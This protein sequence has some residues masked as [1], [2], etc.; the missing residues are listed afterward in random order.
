MF[1]NDSLYDQNKDKFTRIWWSYLGHH[2]REPYMA[3]L[4]ET[5]TKIAKTDS[6]YPSKADLFKQFQYCD[7][8]D[9]KI[10]FIHKF[11]IISY[12]QSIFWQ[13]VSRLIESECVNNLQ[14]N[15]NDNMDYLLSE[16]VFSLPVYRTWSINTDHSQLEWLV[17]FKNVVQFLDKSLNKICFV[18]RSE[19]EELMTGVDFDYHKKILLEE[20]CF[21]QINDFIKKEY[22]IA[23]KW[24]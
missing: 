8:P 14:L 23:I 10:C 16:G 9:V 11:P 15:L 13:N 5:L 24:L 20:G 2:F 12:S 4:Y 17:F 19:L 18:Y 3:K 7:F 6:V 22:N 1:N 21:K